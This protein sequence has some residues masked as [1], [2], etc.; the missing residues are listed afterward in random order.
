[1]KKEEVGDIKKMIDETADRIS[2][3][4][5]GE[6]TDPLDG[7]E[8]D[9]IGTLLTLELDLRQG[10]ITSEEYEERLRMIEKV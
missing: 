6:G 7:D 2:S 3:L 9:R 1:M 4:I 10:N 5:H 8:T